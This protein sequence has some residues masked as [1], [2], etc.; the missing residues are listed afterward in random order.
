[1][2]QKRYKT[3]CHQKANKTSGEYMNE[4]Q[5]ANALGGWEHPEAQRQMKNYVGN[6]RK[7]GGAFLRQNAWC[8]AMNYLYNRHMIE[9]TTLTEWRLEAESVTTESVWSAKRKLSV[10][11][12]NYAAAHGGKPHTIS[13]KDLEAT[14]LGIDGWAEAKVAYFVDK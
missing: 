2:H 12:R 1:M 9:K 6:C 14:D 11:R 7:V 13:A 8:E 3:N 5:I 10:A 4:I